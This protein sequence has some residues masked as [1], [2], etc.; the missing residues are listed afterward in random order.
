MSTSNQVERIGSMRSHSDGTQFQ[1]VTLYGQKSAEQPWS[2]PCMQSWSRI[3]CRS[4]AIHIISDGTLGRDFQDFFPHL[5]VTGDPTEQEVVVAEK[6]SRYPALREIRLRSFL[7]RKILDVSLFL[8]TNARTVLYLD[9]DVFVRNPVVLKTDFDESSITYMRE[10][11]PAY[12]GSWL[13]PLVEPMVLSFNSGFVA[14]RPESIDLEFLDRVT[15]KHLLSLPDHW[16]SEQMAW[17]LIAGRSP[18]RRFWC[19]KDARVI[20]GYGMR[21]ADE[22][23]RN[24]VK[25]I[26]RRALINSGEELLKCAGGASIIHL[27]G[28]AKQFFASLLPGADA[29]TYRGVNSINDQFFKLPTHFSSPRACWQSAFSKRWLVSS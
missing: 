10:D 15:S 26:S 6:L 18:N 14:Y 9:T 4:E 22:M 21:T 16:W 12:L 25:Y 28:H 7:W 5:A 8:P 29:A 2:L 27:T 3:A 11:V 19:D 13:A 23:S 20:S 1:L 24:V 17:S